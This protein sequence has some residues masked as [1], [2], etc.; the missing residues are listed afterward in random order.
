M[1]LGKN[2]I[3]EPFLKKNKTVVKEDGYLLFQWND[4][5]SSGEALVEFAYEKDAVSAEK[6]MIEVGQIEDARV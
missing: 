3:V 5:K 2:M 4:W 1:F 6:E